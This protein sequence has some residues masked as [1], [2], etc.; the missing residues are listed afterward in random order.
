MP[1]NKIIVHIGLHKT[2]TTF[3]QNEIYPRLNSITTIRAWHSHRFIIKSD[4]DKK[5]LFTDEGISGNPFGGN[6]L[7]EFK[8][9]IKKIKHLYDDPKIIFGIRKHESFLCSLYKQYLHQKGH[10]EFSYLFN[11]SNTGLLKTDD[12]LFRNKIETLKKEFSNVFIYSQESL[13]KRP[14]DFINSLINFLEIEDELDFDSIETKER[15]V[16]VN[17]VF[18]VNL[19]KKLNRLNQTFKKYP[20]IPSLYSG[21]LVKYKLTPRDICQNHLK[22]INSEKFELN[23]DIN[24]ELANLFDEDWQHCSK[25]I[26]Y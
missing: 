15:N 11:T 5:I 6:Y 10:E 4:F 3:I 17:T 2:G 8:S 12:L 22:N 19:L 20:F 18:Q 21:R 1:N 26:E 24:N 7:A 14:Q 23:N 13:K 16:G 9:N 25:Y